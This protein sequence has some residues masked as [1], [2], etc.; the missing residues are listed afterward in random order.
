[1]EHGHRHK[2]RIMIG[3]KGQNVVVGIVA[4]VA[5]GSLVATGSARVAAHRPA[6]SERAPALVGEVSLE[7]T[8]ALKLD[9]GSVAGGRLQLAALVGRDVRLLTAP[10][11]R[12]VDLRGATVARALLD[13][14]TI[15]VRGRLL[16]PSSWA[17]DDEGTRVPTLRALQI[18][19]IRL[20]TSEQ[21]DT[22]AQTS[23][24]D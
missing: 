16:P 20:D 5:F 11:T 17:L 12:L 8:G 3:I 10:A 14:A 24:D 9:V 4:L 23:A 21:P 22:T 15:R 13:H 1:M 18:V 19:V 6:P 7:D 2:E